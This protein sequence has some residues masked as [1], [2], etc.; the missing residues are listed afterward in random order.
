L[1]A[2]TWNPWPQA[3]PRQLVALDSL[4]SMAAFAC[5]WFRAAATKSWRQIYSGHGSNPRPLGWRAIESWAALRSWDAISLAAN[6]RPTFRRNT[7]IGCDL[8][9][10]KKL[11][12]YLA[13]ARSPNRPLSLIGT[14]WHP[15][16]NQAKELVSRA[17]ELLV[18]RCLFTALTGTQLAKRYLEHQRRVARRASDHFER[19][20][21]HNGEEDRGCP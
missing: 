5:A 14:E 16:L 3:S 21:R 1:R 8:R 9:N 18:R 10:K 17:P 2:M 6:R 13:R 12:P 20:T 4:C 19:R 15:G 7:L 11:G